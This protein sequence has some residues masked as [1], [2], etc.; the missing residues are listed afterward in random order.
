MRQ[1]ARTEG[2]VDDDVVSIEVRANITVGVRE[3]R[4][5]SSLQDHS[6]RVWS[7]LTACPRLTQLSV[8]IAAA[9]LLK[10]VGIPPALRGKNQT[11]MKLLVR[12][13]AYQ[14]PP[15]ALNEGP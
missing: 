10:S 6:Q 1:T 13:I 5:R 9:P 11:L 8:L 14:P 4:G 7:M 3:K 12:S 2:Q 15:M